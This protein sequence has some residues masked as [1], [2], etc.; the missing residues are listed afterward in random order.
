MV[1]PFT[2]ELSTIKEFIMV[3]VKC[4]SE[5]SCIN[6][7]TNDGKVSEEGANKDGHI[8]E[9]HNVDVDETYQADKDS[10]EP[11]VDPSNDPIEDI[12][13]KSIVHGEESDS[14]CA[15]ASNPTIR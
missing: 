6:R 10:V 14:R 9:D 5:S 12:M 2:I 7:D 4:V 11:T 3:L 15:S 13:V 8:H 1:S